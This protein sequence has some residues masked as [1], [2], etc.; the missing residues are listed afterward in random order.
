MPEEGISFLLSTFKDNN[1]IVG[2]YS[3][4]DPDGINILSSSSSLDN[5][6]SGSKG[7]SGYANVLVPQSPDFSA[8][9]GTW[10]FVSNINDRVKLVMRNGTTPSNAIIV[11]NLIS[12][13]QLGRNI[14]GH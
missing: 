10:K 7:G 11:I 13:E 12:L 5:K 1:S 8:K 14:S 4:T 9:S 3:L 2:F 6:V